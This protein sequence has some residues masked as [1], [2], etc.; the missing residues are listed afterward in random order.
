MEAE[1]IKERI[2]QATRIAR[3]KGHGELAE[4]FAQDAVF[5]L[6]QGRKAKFGQMLI[7]YLRQEYGDS[8]RNED[9]KP[10]PRYYERAQY[11]EID[12]RTMGEA[13]PHNDDIDFFSLIKHLT[14]N[15]RAL[16]TLRHKWDMELTEIGECFGIS[17]SRVCQQLKEIYKKLAL[18]YKIL[19][20]NRMP[21]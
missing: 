17:H 3:R 5:K 12:P 9:S 7:D 21:V 13:P 16:I 11:A 4:D 8:R 6:I 18:N 1:K 15:E 14:P 19:D 10:G 2:T 20:A